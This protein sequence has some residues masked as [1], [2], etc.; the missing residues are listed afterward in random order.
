[1]HSNTSA[2]HHEQV[3]LGLE[4][5]ALEAEAEVGRQ[6]PQSHLPRRVHL[7][8]AAFA[9][10]LVVAAQQLRLQVARL[11]LL[12]ETMST[13]CLLMGS[14]TQSM[15]LLTLKALGVAAQQL[16]LQVALLRLST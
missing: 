4:D 1:M 2:A 14:V 12:S 6:R 16:R 8:G 11:H 7:G 3:H 13:K 15:G 10:V 5:E 9:E